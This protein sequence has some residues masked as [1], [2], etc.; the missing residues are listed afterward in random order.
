[1]YIL[2]STSVKEYQHQNKR[3]VSSSSKC[4]KCLLTYCIHVFPFDKY[5]LNQEKLQAAEIFLCGAEERLQR[6]FSSPY[7][8]R[9]RDDCLNLSYQYETC[10]NAHKAQ[11]DLRSGERLS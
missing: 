5:C 4:S 9:E 8:Q 10:F 6:Q 3:E 1:M 7:L 2:R 11:K